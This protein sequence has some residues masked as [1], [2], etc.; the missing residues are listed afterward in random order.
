MSAEDLFS[1]LFGGGGGRGF[2]GGR[3]SGPRK[4]KDMAHG[5]KVTLNDLYK[6][7]TSKLA[8]QKQVL[9]T[10]CE[11]RGGKAGNFSPLISGATQTCRGCNGRGIKIVMRQM[12]PMIQQMQQ[13]CPDCQGQGETISDKDKCR[14]CNGRKVSNDRKILEVFVEKGMTGIISF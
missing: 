1:Q 6:G 2:G 12:G 3:A 9:C 5:L 10:G 11:G 7:K 13:T 14:E 4:G 8:L